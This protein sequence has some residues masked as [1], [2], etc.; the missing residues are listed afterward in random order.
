MFENSRDFTAQG[1]ALAEKDAKEFI[2]VEIM[3]HATAFSRA[4]AEMLQ[5]VSASLIFQSQSFMGSMRLMK[6]A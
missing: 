2:S 4:L 1:S 5:K 3:P 6:H